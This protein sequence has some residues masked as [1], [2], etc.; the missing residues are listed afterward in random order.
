[1]STP[2]TP[3]GNCLGGVQGIRWNEDPVTGHMFPRLRLAV[4]PN[5]I[6]L[7]GGMAALPVTDPQVGDR[8]WQ[9]CVWPVPLATAIDQA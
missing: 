4:R 2:E 1:M 8:A 7:A 5:L 9:S 6:Q 3:S